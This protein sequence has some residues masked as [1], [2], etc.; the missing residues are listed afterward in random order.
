MSEVVFT[1][2]RASLTGVIKCDL[3]LDNSLLND[4]N[5]LGVVGGT[6][7]GNMTFLENHEKWSAAEY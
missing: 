3:C 5:K 2:S 7:S 6:C 1:C 4:V